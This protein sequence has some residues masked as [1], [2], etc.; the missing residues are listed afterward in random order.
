M[1]GDRTVRQIQ[2]QIDEEKNTGASIEEA[3]RKASRLRDV[4]RAAKLLEDAEEIVG[5]AFTLLDGLGL[6]DL[7]DDVN[8]VG[9]SLSK[10]V[11]RTVQ[12]KV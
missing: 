2:E 1:I 4:D 11:D 8:S 7:A 9:I 5:S 12:V 3:K 10:L 6:E